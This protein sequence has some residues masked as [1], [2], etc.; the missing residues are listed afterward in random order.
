MAYPLEKSRHDGGQRAGSAGAPATASELEEGRIARSNWARYEYCKARGH[1]AFCERA[2]MLEGMYAGGGLQWRDEDKD[3][4]EDEGRFPIELNEVFDAINSALGNQIQNRV[5]IAFRARNSQAT[6][7]MATVLSKVAMQIADNNQF[8]HKETQVTGDGFIQSRGYF[9]LR[10]DYSDSLTGEIRLET[11]DPMDVIPDPDG[12]EYDP[13]SWRDVII[14]R[15]MSLDD[16]EAAYGRLARE[17]IELELGQNPCSEDDFGEDEGDAV[18]RNR[19]G[20]QSAIGQHHDLD[21]SMFGTGHIMVRVIDRQHWRMTPTDV[22]LYPSGDIRVI[23]DASETQLQ[24]ARNAGGIMFRRPTKRV[25][26]TVS[27]Y[28]GVLLHDDWSPYRH[29]TVIPF[30]PYFRRGLT[31]G[32]VDNAV[33]AQE[34]LNKAASQFVHI[35]NTL[36]NSGWTV[37]QNSLTNMSTEELEENGAATGLIIEYK[38]GS[39]KPEKITANQVP[40]GIEHLLQLG[41]AKIRTITGITDSFRGQP[42]GSNQ[43]GRAV[44]ALQ[45]G[46]QL[47]LSV[48]LDNLARTRHMVAGRMLSLIQSFMDAPQVMR[49]VQ[50]AVDGGESTEDLKL[51]WPAPETVNG[52]L[53]D[54][55]IGEY[56]A[57]VTEKPNAVTFEQ[58]QHD[59]AMAMKDKGAPIPWSFLIRTSS[60]SDKNE[61]IELF[62]GLEQGER[63][64]ESEARASLAQAQAALAQAKAVNDSVE[65]LFSAMRTSQ[66]LRGDPALA[67]L[68]DKILM[69]AGF[70]D[71]TPGDPIA[72]DASGL[73]AGQPPPVS[74][75]PLTPD[76]PA[77]GAAVGATAV[78]PIN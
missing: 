76:N 25:R 11:L 6:D 44:Q 34:M 75:N 56:D 26:W 41:S 36:A 48:P 50:T 71:K 47:A 77:S 72:P 27:T 24:A 54:L 63:D 8:R 10:V 60:L 20:D 33:G 64:A 73:P 1:A 30:F 65:A 35:I 57:V 42:V 23:E 5:D 53:N 69:S 17:K 4:L 12:K 3:A 49:I 68:A 19:F 58:N 7:D 22:V 13:D 70:T 31:R 45:Y 74:S 55:T 67:G 51:N 29:F 16:I 39:T 52:V 46:S 9:D 40:S 15:W 61:L 62:K 37:E 18:I 21:E 28:G 43:S 14:T 59:Q 2:K 38:K 66:L 78:S 32:L